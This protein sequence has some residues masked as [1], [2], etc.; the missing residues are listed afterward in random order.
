MSITLFIIK[1][2]LKDTSRA[3]C[4]AFRSLRNSPENRFWTRWCLDITYLS[5]YNKSLWVP[6][7][8]KPPGYRVPRK[9]KPESD[10]P[11]VRLS[12]VVL[13]G[14]ENCPVSISER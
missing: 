13:G 1:T 7:N 3:G 6:E 8:E 12:C 11:S 10:T 5:S 4:R 9:G 14:T 2:D